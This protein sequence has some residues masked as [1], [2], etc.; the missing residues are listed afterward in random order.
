MQ[1]YHVNRMDARR[2]QFDL[3][4]WKTGRV[5]LAHG[6]NVVVLEWLCVFGGRGRGA[7]AD[8]CRPNV[9]RVSFNVA[10]VSCNVATLQETRATLH[11][12]ASAVRVRQIHKAFRI[13]VG[14]FYGVRAGEQK[15]CPWGPKIWKI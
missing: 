3:G 8:S 11:A 12:S 14:L 6:S 5:H 9:A 1:R 13:T 15:V 2:S 7:D 10:G 4:S